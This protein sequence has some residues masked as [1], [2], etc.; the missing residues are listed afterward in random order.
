[1]PPAAPAPQAAPPAPAPQVAQAPAPPAPAPVVQAPP[2]PAPQP[3]VVYVQT[4]PPQ[5]Q[6]VYAQ[7]QPTYA[8]T[9]PQPAPQQ[10]NGSVVI[11]ATE[12]LDLQITHG[13]QLL[14]ISVENGE[15]VLRD[16]S[17][18]QIRFP[19]NGQAF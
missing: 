6:V 5:P 14:R 9:A 11:Q 4:P 12:N 17:G 15:L 2:Q 7:P 10:R 16:S 13:T 8:A 1:A 3:Q 18:T 19:K